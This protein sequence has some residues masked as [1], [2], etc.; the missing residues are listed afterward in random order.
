MLMVIPSFH[1]SKTSP[2]HHLPYHPPN[3]P[4]STFTVAPSVLLSHLHSALQLLEHRESTPTGMISLHDRG[5]PDST[6]HSFHLLLLKA[7]AAR[8]LTLS[9]FLGLNFPMLVQ[10]PQHSTWSLQNHLPSR[11]RVWLA[12]VLTCGLLGRVGHALQLLHLALITLLTFQCLKHFQMSL[13][14][15]ATHQVLL[16]LGKEKGS[17]K[18]LDQMILN[19]HLVAQRPGNINRN[20]SN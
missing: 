2:L 20:V 18:N 4:I 7:P 12:V 1:G 9:G 15:E 8:L 10:L 6:T 3:F 13:H 19:S 11:K 5:G 16:S 14:L 17:M